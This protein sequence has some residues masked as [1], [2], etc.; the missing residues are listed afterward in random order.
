MNYAHK[1][2]E[3]VEKLTVPKTDGALK[4]EPAV[5]R[6][7]IIPYDTRDHIAH[8]YADTYDSHRTFVE[9]NPVLFPT[10]ERQTVES[11]P[12]EHQSG[13]HQSRDN[14]AHVALQRSFPRSPLDRIVES[15]WNHKIG[16]FIFLY[17]I[18]FL[19]YS[20]MLMT[21]FVP[22][23]FL[24]ETQARIPEVNRIEREL[25]TQQPDTQSAIAASSSNTA[26]VEQV[27]AR[28][29]SAESNPAPTTRKPVPKPLQTRAGQDPVR[30]IIPSVGVDTRILNPESS[31]IAALDEQLKRGAVRYPGAPGLNGGGNTLI[32]AHSTS[33]A[34][35]NNPA[36]KAFNGLKNLQKG[37]T[38]TVRSIDHEYTYKVNSVA[39]A[40]NSD[41]YVDF[42]A[43]K[44]ILTLVTCNTLGAKEDRYVVEASLVSAKQLSAAG[45]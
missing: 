14:T 41:I 17:S 42:N 4:P 43:G 21:G 26:G 45:V 10:F 7:R 11:R 2:K 40:K 39:L 25:P 19:L 24:A 6:A 38:I 29:Q 15:I 8:A 9:S 12:V 37:E 28:S 18:F 34:V 35:V 30:I 36:Y 27:N 20:A 16:F 5:H 13:G 23:L 3:M 44:N 33:I 1:I 22:T 31:S 32:F